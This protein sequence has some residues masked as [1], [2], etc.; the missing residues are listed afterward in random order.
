MAKPSL[1]GVQQQGGCF[2]CTAWVSIQ[3]TAS[4]PSLKSADRTDSSYQ[5]LQ[6]APWLLVQSCTLQRKP[7]I[8][9]WAW[10]CYFWLFLPGMGFS[11][12]Q[13]LS[14]SS[15]CAG[16]DLADLACDRRLCGPNPASSL[17]TLS[18]CLPLSRPLAPPLCHCLLEGENDK[19]WFFISHH[20]P[21]EFM[22]T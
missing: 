1:V 20:P 14:C 16:Y 12:P 5:S 19:H 18:R 9:G 21:L 17:L 7:F 22:F 8:S 15:C 13:S 3:G 2:R 4:H 10:W 6:D 11:N